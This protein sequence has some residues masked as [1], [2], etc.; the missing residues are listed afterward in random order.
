M[1]YFLLWKDVKKKQVFHSLLES[2]IHQGSQLIPTC[3]EKGAKPLGKTNTF[4]LTKKSSIIMSCIII[5]YA[6]FFHTLNVVN[7]IY[8][9]ISIKNRL[10]PFTCAYTTNKLEISNA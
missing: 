3:D 1:D 2:I 5:C 8:E 10:K 7:I 9:I 4:L 6:L